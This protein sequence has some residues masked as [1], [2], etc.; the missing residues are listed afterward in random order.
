MSRFYSNK[1][2]GNQGHGENQAKLLLPEFYRNITCKH[3]NTA[4]FAC[5]C[6]VYLTG[7]F[8][9]HSA[10]GWAECMD[11]PAVTPHNSLSDLRLL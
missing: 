6:W 9:R 10:A 2:A 3:Y 4:L 7:H 8:H 11:G 1:A 5:G